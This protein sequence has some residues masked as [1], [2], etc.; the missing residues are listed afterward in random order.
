[1]VLWV[2][3]VVRVPVVYPCGWVAAAAAS[4]VKEDPLRVLCQEKV[5]IPNL[6]YAFCKMHIAFAPSLSQINSH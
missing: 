1:M 6:K 3:P 5:K 4:I 2:Q